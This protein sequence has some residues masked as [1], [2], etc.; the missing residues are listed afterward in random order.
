MP[1]ND[2]AAAAA[3]ALLV[4]ADAYRGMAASAAMTHMENATGLDFDND[5][6]VGNR[7]NIGGA[8]PPKGYAT[9]ERHTSAVYGTHAQILKGLSDKGGSTARSNFN[10]IKDKFGRFRPIC[11]GCVPLRL[12]VF[13]N[14]V[15]T[16]ALSIIMSVAKDKAEEATRVVGG[17]YTIISKTIIFFIE[18]TGIFWGICGII[19]AYRCEYSYVW[20][21][22]LYQWIRIAAWLLMFYT[23][24][25]TLWY[26]ELWIVDIKGA[27]DEMGWNPTVYEIAMSGGCLKERTQFIFFSSCGFFI[28]LYLAIS[29][30]RFQ[31]ELE[32]EPPY[33][34]YS[35]DVPKGSFFSR[36]SGERRFLIHNDDG[37]PSYGVTSTNA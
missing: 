3:A 28:F 21:Y 13:L 15:F 1:E 20:L 4:R 7:D 8:A 35:K 31:A 6:F 23:D 24:L 30:Q 16:L 36:N 9:N 26:C 2:P 17:G 19:G 14:A 25:P 12:G 29:N 27:H 10:G 34:F 18:V 5:G 11:C 22:N 33:L 32:D 37:Y